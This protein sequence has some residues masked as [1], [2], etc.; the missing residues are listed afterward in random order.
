M[1]ILAQNQPREL[2]Y[3]ILLIKTNP[4]TLFYLK[5]KKNTFGCILKSLFYMTEKLSCHALY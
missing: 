4:K 5:N 2:K 3:Y 1:R